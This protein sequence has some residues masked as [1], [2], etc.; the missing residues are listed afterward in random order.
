MFFITRRKE[1]RRN[2]EMSKFVGLV[3]YEAF[4][5]RPQF[6]QL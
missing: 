5:M 6:S 4:V 3:D 1:E 2:E